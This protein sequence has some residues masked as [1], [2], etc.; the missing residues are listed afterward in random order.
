M[1]EGCLL[2]VSVRV[3][4]GRVR[5]APLLVSSVDTGFVFSANMFCILERFDSLRALFFGP[6]SVTA[7][8]RV[9]GSFV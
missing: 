2:C 9:G 7:A 1:P 4:S 5:P 6:A 8:W 3:M